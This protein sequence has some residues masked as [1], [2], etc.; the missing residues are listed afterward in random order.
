MN[1]NSTETRG[2]AQVVYKGPAPHVAPVVL[3]MI[4]SC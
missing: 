2:E 1:T 4:Y 3:H